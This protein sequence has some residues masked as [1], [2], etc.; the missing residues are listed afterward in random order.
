MW[1]V[2]KR[3]ILDPGIIELR[4]AVVIENCFAMPIFYQV[5]LLMMVEAGA[6]FASPGM[7]P[8]ER[9]ERRKSRRH[10]NSSAHQSL[11]KAFLFDLPFQVLS[12]KAKLFTKFRLRHRVEQIDQRHNRTTDEKGN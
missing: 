4:H 8:K 7:T 12:W 6:N 1:L 9:E 10:Q 11:L 5:D 2:V 3:N